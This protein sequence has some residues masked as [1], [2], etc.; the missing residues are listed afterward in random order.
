MSKTAQMENLLAQRKFDELIR[1]FGGEDFSQW[2]F[3]QIGEGAFARAQAFVVSESGEKAEADL[4]TALEYTAD[5][6]RKTSILAAM[7]DNRETNLH[8]DDA[9]LKAYRQ[10]FVSKQ[11]IG[12]AEEF[13]SVQNAAGI[14]T[15]RGKYDEALESLNRANIESLKGFWRHSMLL[16]LGETLAAAGR[17]DEALKAFRAVLDDKAAAAAHRKSADERIQQLKQQ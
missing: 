14:L 1:Q 9:A 16:A 8:D 6:H 13:R 5:A 15:R 7:G 10:N 3:W 4:Q 2:P 12:A 17:N 11:K